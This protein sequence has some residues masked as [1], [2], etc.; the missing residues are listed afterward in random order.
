PSTL[1]TSVSRPAPTPSLLPCTTLFR[2]RRRGPPPLPVRR[3]DHPGATRRPCVRGD[4]P[5][6]AASSAAG[7]GGGERARAVGPRRGGDAARSEE[8]TSELQSREKPVCRRIF[9]KIKR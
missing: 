5:D 1:I 9:G 8:H 7:P 6:R 2:S 4:P 3:M